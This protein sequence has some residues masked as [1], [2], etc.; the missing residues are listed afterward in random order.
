MRLLGTPAVPSAHLRR[1]AWVGVA[2]T[3]SLAL[4]LSMSSISSSAAPSPPGGE[5]GVAPGH[6]AAKVLRNYDVRE[7]GSS[8]RLVERRE[9][10]L[11]ANPSS[12]VTTL[13]Q[14]LGV[15]GVISIDPLTGTP[16]TVA[17]LDGFLTGRSNRRPDVIVER[18][19][20]AHPGV[21]GLDRA[22]LGTLRLRN[23]YTD[24]SGTRHLS[25]VQYAGEVPV[26]DNGL[27][28]NVAK[29]GR[30]INVTGSP[31][32]AL[33]A[34]PT[35]PG[36][37]ARSARAAAIRNVDGRVTAPRAD[38]AAGLTRA[39]TFSDDDRASLVVFAG[40]R[41]ARL[42]WQTLV[43]PRGGQMFLHVID[44]ASGRVL[45]RQ[46]LTASDTG[47]V[48]EY[49][50]GRAD[51]GARRTVDLTRPGWLPASSPRLAG[52]NAHVW[53]DVNDDDR[54]QAS[55]EV[56]P[57]PN[58]YR[59]GVRRL[60]RDRRAGMLDLL[61]V[62]LELVDAP[63]LDQEPQAER[64]SGLLLRQ[65]VPRPPAASTHRVHPRG[66]Q[67]RGDRRRRRTDPARRRGRLGPR[68][69]RRPAG[70]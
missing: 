64:G 66:G 24:I 55:E 23:V 33:E 17:R 60:H 5:R 15:Q 53:S 35:T 59:F 42:G 25:W 28:A 51:G 26:F 21:F 22:D 47:S 1:S 6:T 63:F 7:T 48:W 36:I 31:V 46:N 8:V 27:K 16:R 40:V 69:P 38:R 4:A 50:P 49:W 34:V 3:T 29:D 20:A 45:Y 12:A 39:T 43:T 19:V 61:Q 57:G 44:A 30:L 67:L 54:A 68:P 52:N 62:L 13:R 9:Q 65:Q 14:S 70:R 11:A 10:R 2:L 18:Y 58:S 56:T 32:H 41:G 37:S